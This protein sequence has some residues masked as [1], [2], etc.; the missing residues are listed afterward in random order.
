MNRFQAIKDSMNHWFMYQ[1]VAFQL[2][3]WRVSFLLHDV[4]KM[5]LCLIFG[6]KISTKIHRL[7]SSHHDTV[8]HGKFDQIAAIIDWECARFTKPDKPLNARQTWEKYYSHIDME[9]SF[10]LLKL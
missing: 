7:I 3:S 2:N 1:K 6:D 4:E 10:Q 5:I 9:K 8:F